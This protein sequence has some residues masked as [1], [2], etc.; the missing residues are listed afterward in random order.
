MLLVA[1][2]KS[3]SGKRLAQ[4]QSVQSCFHSLQTEAFTF[5]GFC[6]CCHSCFESQELVDDVDNI[7]MPF[8]KLDFPWWPGLRLVKVCGD[9]FCLFLLQDS[10]MQLLGRASKWPLGFSILNVFCI[11]C[12]IFTSSDSLKHWHCLKMTS[13]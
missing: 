9:A 5:D 11:C 12:N 1:F 8:L 4:S 10:L 13:S 7:L 2:N 3:V 6:S